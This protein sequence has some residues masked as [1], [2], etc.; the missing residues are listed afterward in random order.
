MKLLNLF[1]EMTTK[2]AQYKVKSSSGDIIYTF[3]AN[4]LKY[5]VLF[6]KDGP[7]KISKDETVS[8]YEV[9][10][11]VDKGKEVSLDNTNIGNANVVFATVFEIL[12]KFLS[13]YNPDVVYFS[14][15]KTEKE[16]NSRRALYRRALRSITN[17]KYWTKFMTLNKYDEYYI[18][19]NKN[20]IQN[21]Y[22]GFT[23]I[24]KLMMG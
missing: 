21:D 12:N 24:N 22:Q 4:G 13:T 16:K 10:F 18:I 15:I 3:E 19:I 17:D 23:M 5:E 8:L 11:G 20:K 9:S 1:E 6:A 2:P 14:S 7:V